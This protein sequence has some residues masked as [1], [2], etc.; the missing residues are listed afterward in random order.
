MSFKITCAGKIPLSDHLQSHVEDF[1]WTE[2]IA[3]LDLA[4]THTNG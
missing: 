3:T 4:E 1:M 2:A